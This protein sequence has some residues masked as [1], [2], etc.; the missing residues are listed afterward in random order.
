MS[1]LKKFTITLA[2]GMTFP[3]EQGISLLDAAAA[4][5]LAFP[6]SCRTGRCRTC[7]CRLISGSTDCIDAEAGL[8][9]SEEAS[10]WVLT[11]VRTALSDLVID[12]NVLGDLEIPESRTFPCRIHDI[13]HLATDVLLVKLRLPPSV[14]FH[15][16]PG[17]YIDLIG[18]GGDRRSY[19]LANSDAAEKMLE[20]HIRLVKNGVLS[21]Y[22][23]ETAKV[24]DLLRLHGPLGTFFLRGAGGKDLVFL[25]TGTGLA[26]IKSILGRLS[27]LSPSDQPKTVSLYW[28]GRTSADL[29]WSSDF[30]F[31]S[32]RYIPVLSRPEPSW[33]GEVGYVQ[34]IL[35]SKHSDL[36]NMTVYACGSDAMI[37]SAEAKL[38]AAGL[39]DRCFI[40]D[41]FVCSAKF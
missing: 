33:V 3:C 38:S 41:A 37:K 18:P 19:S 8:S 35:L 23:F 27:N 21:A 36:S 10:G 40:S 39:P 6:Y 34:D 14:E 7:K 26:P 1:K 16:L 24:N 9:E 28:G 25:A 12:A 31:K 22:W 15:F 4:A 32:L 5:G 29:Y 2:D 17:Q 13:Q 11:C 30:L 20:L